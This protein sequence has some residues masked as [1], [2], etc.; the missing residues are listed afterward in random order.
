MA[1][2]WDEDM[3]RAYASVLH[4]TAR[5]LTRNRTDAEDLVQ[6]T[7]AKALAAADRFEHG[8]NL[9]AWLHRIMINTYITACRRRRCDEIPVDDDMAD[10][11]QAFTRAASAEDLALSRIIDADVVTAIRALPEKHRLTVY[12]ADAEGLDYKQIAGIAGMPVGSVKSS[13]HRA[14]GTLRAV[15]AGHD[16]GPPG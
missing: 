15:L 14:R 2:I 5:R 12:L 6:E 7:F 11:H 13:L 16:A 10:W 3:I 4:R 9:N 1:V 8:T